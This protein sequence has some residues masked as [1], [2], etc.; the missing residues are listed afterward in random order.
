L[1]H[2]LLDRSR[3]AHPQRILSMTELSH[4]WRSMT[5]RRSMTAWTP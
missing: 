4:E 2:A 3:P 1:A 5:V